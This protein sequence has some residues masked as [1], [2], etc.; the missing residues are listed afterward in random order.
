MS[1]VLSGEVDCIILVPVALPTMK[2]MLK[3]SEND[4]TP[5]PFT[6]TRQDELKA[7]AFNGY[8]AITG[9]VSVKEYAG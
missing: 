5:R 6:T 7:L 2:H 3:G 1:A 9:R 4:R 8:L